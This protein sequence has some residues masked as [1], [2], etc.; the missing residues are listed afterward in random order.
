MTDIR[1]ELHEE[2]DQLS[3]EELVGLQEFLRTFPDVATAVCRRA[4]IDPEPVTEAEML[5]MEEAEE[6]FEQN[7]GIPHEEVM[8]EHGLSDS[9]SPVSVVWS[10]QASDDL[11]KLPKADADRV[12]RA[13]RRLAEGKSL[14]SE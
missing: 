1:A 5:A 4:P 2:V 8:R 7:E 9:D 13:I 12:G 14:D 11:K 3:D 6:W 10:K